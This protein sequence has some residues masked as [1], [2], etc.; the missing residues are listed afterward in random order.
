MRK[1]PYPNTDNTPIKIEITDGLDR[2][3]VP[4][5]IATIN[6]KCTLNS[7]NLYV[8]DTDGKLLKLESRL[9][10]GKDIAPDIMQLEGQVTLFGV[11]HKIYKSARP[12]NP[13]GTVHHTKL[14]L[15]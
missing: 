14:E 1:L 5:I 2:D 11:E 4:K 3:G 15:I 8:R 6:D 9:Y 10:I 7:K 12:R 13:D